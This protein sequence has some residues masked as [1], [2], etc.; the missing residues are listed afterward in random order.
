MKGQFSKNSF[1][2]NYPQLIETSYQGS[3]ISN[4]K[5]IIKIFKDAKE[6]LKQIKRNRRKYFISVVFIDEIGL[7]EISPFN[8]L[9]VL[10][11]FLELDYKNK[12]DIEKI[13]FVGISNWKLDASKM[14]RGIYLNVYSPESNLDEMKETAYKILKTYFI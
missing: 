4:P 3:L 6:K 7:C 9:K 2:K 5:G 11:S 1:W 8:P 10:H 13:A 14:N 12:S